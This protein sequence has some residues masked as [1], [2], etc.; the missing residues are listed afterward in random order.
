MSLADRLLANIALVLLGAALV[1]ALVRRRWPQ[2]RS[3]TAFLA[4]AVL[5][6]RLVTWWPDTF[7]NV[8]FW[9]TKEVLIASL[10][11]GTVFE[12]A[13]AALTGV[14]RGRRRAVA[15]LVVL[16]GQVSIMA[17]AAVVPIVS[18]LPQHSAQ[19]QFAL[20]VVGHLELCIAW[21]VAALLLVTYWYRLPLDS[22]NQQILIGLLLG[23]GGAAIVLGLTQE[24]VSTTLQAL[25]PAMTVASAGVWAYAAWFAAAPRSVRLGLARLGGSSEP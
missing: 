23:E 22:Y 4:L 10:L 19:L 20:G 12:I 5:T 18:F 6:N 11:L 15:W 24:R 13:R 1:G 16:V 3:F 9:L 2:S 8:P 21:S 7:F 25:Y 14:P 17:V